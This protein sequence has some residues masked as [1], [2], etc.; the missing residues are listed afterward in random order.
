MRL[1][2]NV[3]KEQDM[4]FMKVHMGMNSKAGINY[5]GLDHLLCH[6]MYS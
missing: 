5:N 3:H 1:V 4:L 6:Y 2:E